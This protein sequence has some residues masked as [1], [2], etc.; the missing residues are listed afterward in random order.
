MP[1]RP[2][3]ESGRL[4]APATCPRSMAG[5]AGCRCGNMG[6]RLAGRPR[7]GAGVTGSAGARRATEDA[8]S[9]TCLAI[10]LFVRVVEDI[11]SGV[12]IKA[13]ILRPA[14]LRLR[15]CAPP[16]PEQ[17]SSSSENNEE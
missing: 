4:L 2:L 13:Q 9:V 11:A 12:V 5:V 1:G 3:Y 8:R 7:P 10:D 6:C 16:L 14:F 17:E 15:E